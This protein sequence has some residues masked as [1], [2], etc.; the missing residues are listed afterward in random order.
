MLHSHLVSSSNL[1]RRLLNLLITIAAAYLVVLILIR[2]FESHFVFFPNYPGRL[3]GDWHPAALPIQDVSITTS[4]GV[5]LHAW[6]IPC[7]AAKFTFLAFH[8]NASNIA[9]RATVYSFLHSMPANV[10]AVEYRGYGKSTGTP[11]EAGI[12]R[13]ADAAYDYLTAARHV[14]PDSIISFGQSLGTAVATDLASRHR[15]AAL[16]LEAP[17]PSASAVARRTFPFLPGLNLL[18]RGQFDT[19]TKIQ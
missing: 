19:A 4:D 3:D 7:E 6:W 14:P 12:Y 2:V 13:D 15:V 9:N 11:S 1:P 17:F 10:L 8:G 18:V 16:V 5:S